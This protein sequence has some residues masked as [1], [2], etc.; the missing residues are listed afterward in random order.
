MKESALSFQVEASTTQQ[1]ETRV[2]TEASTSGTHQD[3][4]MR[5]YIKTNINNLLLHHEKRTRTSTMKKAKKK[6]KMKKMFNEDPSK[7]SHEFEQ[8]SLET[9]PSSKSTMIS[10]PGE[11]LALNFIWLVFVNIIHS[12][13]VLNL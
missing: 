7:S 1:G 3:E 10:K 4:K 5:K 9:I 13:L 12:P 8:E 2:D 6:N 11:S